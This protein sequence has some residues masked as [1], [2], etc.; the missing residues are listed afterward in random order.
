MNYS[1]F[2]RSGIGLS[3]WS[4]E[5]LS[6]RAPLLQNFSVFFRYRRFAD[7]PHFVQTAARGLAVTT[8]Y[9][10]DLLH[11]K[12]LCKCMGL[13]FVMGQIFEKAGFRRKRKFR[14]KDQFCAKKSFF[15]ILG[16]Y[17]FFLMFVYLNQSRYQGIC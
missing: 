5:P 3:F 4:G 9:Y 2:K 16:T 17:S 6:P 8:E 10:W 14:K 15:S 7:V 12:L 11:R 1:A 13:V